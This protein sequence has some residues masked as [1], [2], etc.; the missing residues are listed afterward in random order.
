MPSYYGRYST[1]NKIFTKYFWYTIYNDI[2]DFMKKRVT[3][4]KKSLAHATVVMNVI[5][6]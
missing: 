5:G 3:C 2:V 1:Y 4:Q 6:R